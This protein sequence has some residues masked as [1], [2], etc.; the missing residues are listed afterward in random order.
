MSI[1]FFVFYIFL[2]FR[3]SFLSP[4]TKIPRCRMAVTF[5]STKT[6]TSE[7][8]LHQRNSSLVSCGFLFLW[9]ISDVLNAYGFSGW[10]RSSCCWLT[11]PQPNTF[12]A[13][14]PTWPS[15]GV[16]LLP[17]L[18]WWKNLRRC[19]ASWGS[20][21]TWPLLEAY[22][23][24]LVAKITVKDLSMRFKKKKKHPKLEDKNNNFSFVIL[25][26]W[27]AEESQHALWGW[28]L[29]CPKR[30]PDTPALQTNAGQ[31]QVWVSTSI[32]YLCFVV[33]NVFY[34]HFVLFH[35]WRFTSVLVYWRMSNFS[36]TLL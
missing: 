15:S 1:V 28:V 9:N 17:K 7:R 8:L 31:N 20:T 25:L 30:S 26:P 36:N 10:W 12:I 11:F 13:N 16:T 24:T 6:A 35:R 18:K 5:T 22:R 2:F 23:Y 19:A 3:W 29:W 14:S 27:H 21:S 34:L 4:S 32:L 33:L